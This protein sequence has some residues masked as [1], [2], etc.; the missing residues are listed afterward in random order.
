M[1]YQRAYPKSRF[2]Q[3]RLAEYAGYEMDDIPLVR[4]VSIDHFFY[5]PTSATQLAHYARLGFSL[6]CSS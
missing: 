6:S 3:D 5:R 2:S 4:T 1:V